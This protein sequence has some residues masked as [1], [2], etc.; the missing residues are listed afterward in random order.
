MYLYL[1]LNVRICICICIWKK[2]FIVF[3]FVFEKSENLYL[4]L[5]LYL[6]KRIWTQ[7]WQVETKFKEYRKNGTDRHGSMHNQNCWDCINNSR[8][9]NKW[10]SPILGKVFIRFQAFCQ[11]Q[12]TWNR[13]KIWELSCLHHTG[14]S[15]RVLLVRWQGNSPGNPGSAPLTPE[16]CRVPI[17]RYK[18]TLG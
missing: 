18:R 7:P 13:V 15:W 9:E 4:Y 1:Y 8:V 16:S 6:K 3:V 17:S 10:I 2:N 11:W 12:N 14:K 5:Y